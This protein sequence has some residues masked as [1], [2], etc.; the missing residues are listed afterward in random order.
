MHG[1]RLVLTTMVVVSALV[2]A[3][4][5]AAIA[6][7]PYFAGEITIGGKPMTGTITLHLEDQF[8]GAKVK[9]GKFK[10]N[11]V[12]VGKCKVT[13]EG[14]S[15]PAKYKSEDSTWLMI[16][17]KDAQMWHVFDL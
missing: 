6:D 12:L 10:I 13:L 9:K 8:V 14:K 16:D 11:R 2:Y 17:V 7:D 1:V 3:S 15:V 4:A 5:S